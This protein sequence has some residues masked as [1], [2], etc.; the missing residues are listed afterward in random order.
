M[1]GVGKQEREGDGEIKGESG[2]EELQI[3]IFEFC[4]PVQR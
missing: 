1:G 4:C 3:L 2:Q